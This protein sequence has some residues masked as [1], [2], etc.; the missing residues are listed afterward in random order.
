MNEQDLAQLSVKLVRTQET[1]TT[2]V[3]DIYDQLDKM[4]LEHEKD[5][6]LYRFCKLRR[7]RPKKER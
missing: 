1:F 5:D 6:I 7:R 2:D 3:S 4:A